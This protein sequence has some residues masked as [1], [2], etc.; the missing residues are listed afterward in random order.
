MEPVDITDINAY[1]KEYRG[2]LE[3]QTIMLELITSYVYEDTFIT[4]N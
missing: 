3:I 2:L 4:H 1:Q